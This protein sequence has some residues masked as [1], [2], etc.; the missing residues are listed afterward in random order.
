MGRV[1]KYDD[2]KLP[3]VMRKYIRNKSLNSD[4]TS[5]TYK[6][7]LHRL[8]AYLLDEGIN[9]ENLTETDMEGFVLWLKDQGSKDTAISSLFKGIQPFF[10]WYKTQRDVD[11]REFNRIV[12]FGKE[13]MV[14]NTGEHAYP[15]LTRAQEEDLFSMLKNPYMRI[16]AWASIAYGMR[17]QE[18]SNLCM[19]DVQINESG[20]NDAGDEDW[21]KVIIRKSKGNKTRYVYILKDHIPIW[22]FYFRLREKDGVDFP[23]VF[24]WNYKPFTSKRYSSFF[25][26]HIGA[27]VEFKSSSHSMRRTFGTKLYRKGVGLVV[28]KNLMGH[29][30]VDTTSVYLNILDYETQ[31]TYLKSMRD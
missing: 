19:D 10:N 29:E 17:A 25:R 21:G 3:E 9:I 24:Y 20:I 26:K 22:R 16:M 13:R 27:L 12:A 4:S 18:V 11:T 23:N 28:I 1:S 30:S 15:A 2:K 6:S 5:G 14:K 8:N 31:Q 7:H